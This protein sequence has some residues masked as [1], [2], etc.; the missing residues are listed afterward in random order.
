MESKITYIKGLV[1]NMTNSDLVPFDEAKNI[2]KEPCVYMI[3][4]KS[5]LLYIGSTKN[6]YKRFSYQLIKGVK[7]SFANKLLKENIDRNKL[8]ER[9]E[10]KFRYKINVCQNIREAEALEHLLIYLLN[11][12]HN[13]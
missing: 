13:K 6:I 2:S 9:I 4:S 1:N 3:Y 12:K 5:K 11:P 8:K 7:H 10:N